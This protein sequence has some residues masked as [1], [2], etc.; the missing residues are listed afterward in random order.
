MPPD[1]AHDIP[2]DDGPSPQDV[3]GL[4]PLGVGPFG[5][6]PFGPRDEDEEETTP[7]VE[8]VPGETI[9][10]RHKVDVAIS[11]SKWLAYRAQWKRERDAAARKIN[12]R[13]RRER[14]EKTKVQREA[15]AYAAEVDF[16]SDV[17]AYWRQT[18]AMYAEAQRQEAIQQAQSYALTLAAQR[19]QQMQM[20]IMMREE[21]AR[22]YRQALLDQQQEEQEALELL[23]AA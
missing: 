7:P 17:E 3:E 5:E 18:A 8:T 20:A 15:T 23:L 10:Q 1:P 6:G 22:R 12:A 16:F 11:R 9:L 2:E 13:R 19:Y 14:E 21:M 4:A